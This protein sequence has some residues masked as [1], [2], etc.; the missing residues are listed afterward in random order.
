MS[1]LT[2][3][4]IPVAAFNADLL[5]AKHAALRILADDLAFKPW[6]HGVNF[7]RNKAAHDAAFAALRTPF[8]RSNEPRPSGRGPQHA[9][10][11]AQAPSASCLSSP[12]CAPAPVAAATGAV[13]PHGP[14]AHE[15]PSPS[16]L[17]ATVPS[18]LPGVQHTGPTR[19]DPLTPA[20]LTIA[21]LR[22]LVLMP[23]NKPS[24]ARRLLD[25]AGSG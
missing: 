18:C 1:A 25:R 24:A 16:C 5:A 2:L 20:P 9:A 4:P 13:L 17:D 10:H 19:A 3:D 11:F 6:R 7:E 12:S 15:P 21:D 23:F 14:P 8:I 22:R